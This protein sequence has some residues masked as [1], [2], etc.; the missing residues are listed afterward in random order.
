M[1]DERRRSP[2]VTVLG[3]VR[4]RSRETGEPVTLRE[5]GLGGM[6]LETAE[7]FD[8]GGVYDFAL[9]LGDG[10]VL[11]LRARVAH[12]RAVPVPSGGP[13]YLTGFEFIEADA[14]GVG[15]IMDGSS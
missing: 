4:G 10:T 15:Q 11:D 9:E 3:S 13:V 7:P 12:G 8:P 1:K 6:A 2:R 5:I 14:D